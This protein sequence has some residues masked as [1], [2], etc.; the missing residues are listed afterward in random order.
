MKDWKKTLIRADATILEAMKV[1]DESSLQIALVVDEDSR[2]L[3][4]VTD[5]DIRRCILRNVSLE[6]PVRGIMNPDPVV[7]G[8]TGSR[9]EVLALMREKSLHHIPVVDAEGRIVSLQS[10]ETVIH[11]VS[12]DN[13]VVIM[14]GGE[15]VR[16]RP[17]TNDCPK[18]MLKVGGRPIIE[19][20]LDNFI[21]FG[22]QRFFSRSTTRPG[23]S[24]SISVTVLTG[25]FASSTS[26]SRKSWALRV[27]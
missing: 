17:M 11:P 3:G 24:R 26:A 12:R 16:L 19:T 14:A 5:G 13:W 2:L 23:S 25:A 4:T 15:G 1:I 18:P 7:A 20:I 21:E 22:F 10:I 6:E 27:R 9:A 8:D